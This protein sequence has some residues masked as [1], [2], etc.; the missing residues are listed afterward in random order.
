MLHADAGS[1]DIVKG[2]LAL[3]ILRRGL[4]ARVVAQEEDAVGGEGSG[5]DSEPPRTGD[6]LDLIRAARDGAD[7][8]LPDFLAAL[9]GAGWAPRKRCIFGRVTM[10]TEWPLLGEEREASERT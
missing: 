1:D 10:R 3:A 2:T 6:C 5:L 4:A 9:T 8:L 7:R